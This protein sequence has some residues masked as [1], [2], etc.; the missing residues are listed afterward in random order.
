MASGNFNKVL[1][2]LTMAILLLPAQLL[3]Q[4]ITIS[5]NVYDE[6]TK[7]PI[8]YATIFIK[9]TE[10]G[11]NTDESGAFKIQTK[12]S[13]DTILISYVGYVT[14]TLLLSDAPSQH[15]NIYLLPS[16]ISL[17][18]VIIKPR[19]EPAK[20]LMK[21]VIEHKKENDYYSID[22]Y[23]VRAYTKIELDL[24][25]IILSEEKDTSKIKRKTSPYEVLLDH[26]DTTND[27]TNYLPFFFTETLS[28]LYYRES[29]K[30]RKEVIVASR[31]SGINNA[32][33]SQILG[34]YYEQYNIY[35]NYWFVINKNVVP[36]VTDAWNFF[37]RVELTDSAFIGDYWCYKI[38]FS[39]RQ[40]QENVFEGYMWI[41]DEDFAVKEVY[42]SLDRSAN[43]NYYKR[44]EFYQEYEKVDG[45]HWVLKRDK[46]LGEFL[47]LQNSSSVIVRKS[48]HYTTYSFKPDVFEEVVKLRDDI[49]YND[50]VINND[51]NFWASVRPEQLNSNEHG[52]YQ[53]VDSLQNIGSFMTVVDVYNTLMYGYWNLGYV[54]IGPFANMVSS[55]EVEG[56][57]MRLGVKTGDLISKR[58]SIG[59]YLA[60]GTKD[61][62]FKYGSE[63]NLVINKKPWQQFKFTYE[64][65]LDVSSNEGVT[66]GEDNILS[67]FYRRRETPQKILNH[68]KLR[69]H[70]E[71][72]WIWGLSNSIT[73]TSERINPL[74]DIYY[75]NQKDSLVTEINNAELDLGF[76]F[77]YREKFLFDNYRRYSLGTSYPVFTFHY[78]MGIPDLG[79]SDFNYKSFQ[80]SLEDYFLLG[81]FGGT[82]YSIKA[83]KVYGILP[84]LLLESP[85][86]NE[87]YFMNH[88]SFNLM[89][90]YE[91]VMDSYAELFLTHSFHGF[92]LNKIPLI[93]KL[94]LREVATFKMVYGSLSEN[95]TE[96]NNYNNGAAPYYIGNT[97][98]FPIP[99]MEA[100]IGVENIFKLVR[101]DAIW[102]L[103]YRNNP[104]AP[105]FGVRLGV[106]LDI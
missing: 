73:L 19:E 85:P 94:K 43:I 86:G 90:E 67:G 9:N 82:T 98:P 72:D 55:N 18:E 36:P 56:L 63:F 46:I 12:A 25:N 95:N 99:Y 77:A 83:G 1:F 14:D 68:E 23:K 97:A 40:K 5:G 16:D 7:Q 22:A 57:R 79:G 6:K 92:F 62:A 8:L 74:F 50:S 59:G 102:R 103:S 44:A 100:G 60:Y 84:T 11:T 78:K 31:T 29:P 52:V 13:N 39:P 65:D 17:G 41:A 4:T 32:S 48:T 21:K 75:Y 24:G 101:V 106:S 87:T 69:G 20:V 42:M 3:A 61:Q 71:K 38:E 51:E 58:M 91:F 93:Q 104:L 35:N 47:P 10:Y 27:E 70:Y 80:V 88:G 30:T 76:R 37:Y 33:A 66:F 15:Y 49:V 105:N 45:K 26:I 34:N 96:T 89:N 54:R 28:D 53:L 2:C 64:H 81:S